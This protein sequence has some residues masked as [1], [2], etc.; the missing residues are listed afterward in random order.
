LSVSLCGG[1]KAG[2]L[3]LM[4]GLFGLAL[5]RLAVLNVRRAGNRG[6]ANT[7]KTTPVLD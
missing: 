5:A 3:G 6:R 2:R 1:L 7:R 4:L